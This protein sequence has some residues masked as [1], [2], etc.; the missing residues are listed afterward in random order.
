MLVQYSKCL[1]SLIVS[2][3]DIVTNHQWSPVPAGS[4]PTYPASRRLALLRCYTHRYPDGLRVNPIGHGSPLAIWLNPPRMNQLTTASYRLEDYI[5]SAWC[6]FIYPVVNPSCWR[7]TY[8]NPP[9]IAMILISTGNHSLKGKTIPPH[10]E[11]NTTSNTDFGVDRLLAVAAT[12]KG[13]KHTPQK[14]RKKSWILWHPRYHEKESSLY[15]NPSCTPRR[16][17]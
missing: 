12:V 5:N 13:I 4:P 15:W 10:Q 2:S 6:W 9:I 8:I 3:S 17:L 16:L 11:S 7:I 14:K 1:Q